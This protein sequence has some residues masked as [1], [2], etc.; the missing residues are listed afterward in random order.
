MLVLVKCLDNKKVKPP[1]NW[2]I[3]PLTQPQ[4]ANQRK[5]QQQKKQSL[6]AVVNLL[7]E[8]PTGLRRPMWKAILCHG[9]SVAAH[10]K[11]NKIKKKKKNEKTRIF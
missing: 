9:A 6:Y 5:K 2:V 10:V 8:K 1:Y 7:M 4:V 11:T 3:F